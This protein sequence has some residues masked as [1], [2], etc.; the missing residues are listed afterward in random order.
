M[1]GE[2]RPA[3]PDD[4]AARS[5]ELNTQ[6]GSRMGQ[7]SLDSS[8]VGQHGQQMH[9]PPGGGPQQGQGGAGAQQG[10]QPVGK[11]GEK[12]SG[13]PD[14]EMQRKYPTPPQ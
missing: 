8:H 9:S 14:V 3:G 4:K 7:Q 5:G 12:V 1:P 2:E 13:S 10:G 6:S 11:S